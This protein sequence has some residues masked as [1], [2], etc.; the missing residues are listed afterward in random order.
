MRILKFYTQHI[1]YFIKFYDENKI[2]WYLDNC[3][4]Y[5]YD[6]YIMA[7]YKYFTKI[8]LSLLFY[9]K[10]LGLICNNSGTE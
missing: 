3:N 2:A 5:I 1:N 4:I 8:I 6:T 9:L 7:C 10:E